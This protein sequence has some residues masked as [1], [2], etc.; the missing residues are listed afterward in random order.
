MKAAVWM[1]NTL[2]T[3]PVDPNSSP[4]CK[5]PATSRRTPSLPR[6]APT[7]GGSWHNPA[8]IAK[9]HVVRMMALFCALANV[10]YPQLLLEVESR[11]SAARLLGGHGLGNLHSYLAKPAAAVEAVRRS[12]NLGGAYEHL[13]EAERACQLFRAF[14]HAFG[15]TCAA[16]ISVQIHPA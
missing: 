14:E 16:E 12:L 15:N 11:Q 7:H 6:I 8:P 10:V 4:R 5:L 1:A 13:A 9:Q 3:I 2:P